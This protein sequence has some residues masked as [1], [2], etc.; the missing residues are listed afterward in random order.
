MRRFILDLLLV[1]LIVSIVSVMSQSGQ[2]NPKS[3]SEQLA[4]FEDEIEHG[5]IYHPDREV[6]L[7]QT[8]ENRAGKLGKVLSQFVVR[9]V[10][11][12]VNFMKEIW[13]SFS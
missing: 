5:V 1:L 10:E 7:L 2:T 8:E 12:G 11:E 6:Y 9:V 13:I 4:Q 3:L